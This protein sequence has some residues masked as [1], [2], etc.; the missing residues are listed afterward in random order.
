MNINEKILLLLILLKTAQ[1][2]IFIS[3]SFKQYR[4][5]AP[6]AEADFQGASHLHVIQLKTLLKY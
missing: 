3:F 6:S 2:G 1:Q 4:E 5:V